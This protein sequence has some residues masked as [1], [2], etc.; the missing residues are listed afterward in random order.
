MQLR[1]LD[2]ELALPDEMRR[3]IERRIRLAIGRYVT[4]IQRA[5]ITLSGVPEG[6]PEGYCRI[7]VQLRQGEDWT[8]E[9]RAPDVQSAAWDAARRL[10]ERLDRRRASRWGPTRRLDLPEWT[11]R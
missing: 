5:R 10:G 2:D 6:S 1:I 9:G 11:R 3:R 8:I 4:G 7:D